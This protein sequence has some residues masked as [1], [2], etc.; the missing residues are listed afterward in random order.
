MAPT[1]TRRR[2]C[3]RRREVERD[4]SLESSMELPCSHIGSNSSSNDSSC[5]NSTTA[6]KEDINRVEVLQTGCSTPKGQRF[7]IPDTLTCPPAPMKPRVAPKLLSRRSSAITFFAPP[8][9]DLFF[10]LAFQNVSA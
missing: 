10:F 5:R 1:A 9:I 7:R 6:D 8:D 2:S 3:Y 4:S